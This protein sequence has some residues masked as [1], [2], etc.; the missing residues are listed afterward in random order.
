MAQSSERFSILGLIKQLDV[1]SVPGYTEY[2]TIS[3]LMRYARTFGLLLANQNLDREGAPWIRMYTNLH[4]QQ[5]NLAASGLNHVAG[6]IADQLV[7]NW[8]RK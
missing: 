5:R 2:E 3:R 7:T 8:K 1:P 6:I 4:T